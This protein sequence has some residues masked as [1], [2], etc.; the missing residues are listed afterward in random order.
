[1]LITLSGMVGSGKSTTA[2]RIVE[3]LREA[4]CEPRYLRFRFLGL[5]GFA[6]PRGRNA[7][8]GGTPAAD[9]SSSDSTSS[10]QRGHGFALRRLTAVLTAGYALRILSFRLSGIGSRSRCDVVDRYFYDNLI[11]YHLTGRRE[12]AYARFLRWLIPTP[13]LS[14]LVTASE[15]TIAG[16]RA[17]YDRDYI[18]TVARLYERLPALFPEVVRITTDPGNA[19]DDEIRRAVTHAI[20]SART[21][22]MPVA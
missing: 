18:A 22:R 13:D 9:V 5:T 6:A 1:M 17:N 4:G 11:R 10:G 7:T 21:G 12:R 16:R 2:A 8:V 15:L 20:E 3:L 19:A 14:L